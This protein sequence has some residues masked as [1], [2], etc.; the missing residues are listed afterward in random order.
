MEDIWH[1]DNFTAQQSLSGV[2]VTLPAPDALRM[3]RR[4]KISACI[5][6]QLST[7]NG[8]Y[9]ASHEY[10]YVLLLCCKV[11]PLDL[12][13][14]F[15]RCGTRFSISHDLYYKKGGLVNTC[16]SKLCDWVAYLYN[17]AFTSSHMTD[18][19][20]IHTGHVVRQINTV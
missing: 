12:P 19:S 16:H 1:R 17:K 5:S 8:M 2:T 3:W 9:L 20:L 18:D 4:V 6:A 7:V 10:I 15:G 13:H 11:D 14:R